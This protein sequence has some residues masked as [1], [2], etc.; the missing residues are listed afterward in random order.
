MLGIINGDNFL[1]GRK[2]LSKELAEEAIRMKIAAPLGLTIEQGAAAIYAIQNAQTADLV[3]KVVVNSGYDPRDFILYSFG[4]AGPVHA[5]SYSADLG[6]KEVLVPLG[7]TSAV[8]SAYGLATS[9]IVLTAEASDPTNLPADPEKVTATFAKLE[10]ELALRLDQQRLQFDHV[11]YEREADLR[12]TM[13]M[14]EVTTPVALGELNEAN[15]TE[16]GRT[17]EALYERIY[18]KGA[19]FS[20]AG[21]QLITYRVRAVGVLPCSPELPELATGS[22]NPKS[23]SERRV[24]MDVRKG[25]QDTKIY[26][27]HVLGVGSKIYGPAVIEAPT[28]TVALPEGCTGSVD[29][30]G[31]LVIR[32]DASA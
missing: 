10:N 12:Y 19:G 17:F 20:E 2:K 13:Q 24:F 7:S 14:A 22:P 11:F 26:D 1:G 21:I 25:W 31:N 3:R 16:I 4:G 6:I 23:S 30:L 28:T 15:V 5:A 9:D 18:G 8:F 32:Y 29:R 27:Y